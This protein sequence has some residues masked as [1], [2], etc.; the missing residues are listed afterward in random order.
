MSAVVLALSVAGAAWA[1]VAA[2][3]GSRKPDDI[4]D[5]KDVVDWILQHSG[6][7]LYPSQVGPAGWPGLDPALKTEAGYE[8]SKWGWP[9]MVPYPGAVDHTRLHRQRYL[10]VYP[11][12]NAR[13]LVKNFRA[14]EIPGI[15]PKSV[16]PYAEPIYHVPK[17]LYPE[18][19]RGRF[20]DALGLGKYNKPVQTLRFDKTSPAITLDLGTLK[21]SA[22]AVRVIAAIDT[23][24]VQQSTKRLVIHFEVNDGSNGEISAS[25]KRCAAND[26]FYSMAEFFFLAPV[27]RPYRIKLRVDASS[28]LS[29]YLHNIDLHD[30]LAELPN[31]GVKK[32]ASLYDEKERANK[33]QAA[34]GAKKDAR[35]KEQRLNADKQIM[36]AMLPANS[37]PRGEI[38]PWWTLTEAIFKLPPGQKDD[39]MGID[40]YGSDMIWNIPAGEQSKAVGMSWSLQGAV[41]Q[42]ER[43]KLQ[44]QT[45]YEKAKEI[46][47]K[48]K[49]IT[50]PR[51]LP[52]L[53]SSYEEAGD[54]AAARAAA[55][56]LARVALAELLNLDETRQTMAAVDCIPEISSANQGDISLRRRA[57]TKYGSDPAMAKAYDTIF[58][59]IR[60][61]AEL[62]ESLGRFIPWIKTAD[63]MTRFFEVALIQVPAR[64]TMLY[65]RQDGFHQGAWMTTYIV[66]QQDEKVV[67]PWMHWL[68]RFVWAYPCMPTGIDETLFTSWNH[69][70]TTLIASTF[71]TIGTTD[72]IKTILGN[73]QPFA[74]GLHAELVSRLKLPEVLSR[75]YWESRFSR[76]AMV[77]GGYRF[78]VGDVSGPSRGR[79][80]VSG[81][82]T[83]TEKVDAHNP[84]R[85]LANWFAV[86]ESNVAENDFRKRR[87]TGVRVGNGLGHAHA[88]PLDLQIWSL[89]VPLA[90]DWGAR[91]GYCDPD[92][93]SIEAHNTVLADSLLPISSM[94]CRWISAFAATEGAQ[95]LR[96]EVLVPGLYSRQLAL[97]DVPD[98][99]NSYLVD[100][101]RVR[102]GTN[103]PSY[104]FH[105]PPP[106]EF[107]TNIE[108]LNKGWPAGME[109]PQLDPDNNW[110]GAIDDA[111]TATWM[112]G[113]DDK[114]VEFK[115]SADLDLRKTITGRALQIKDGKLVLNVPGAERKAMGPDFNP[116]DPRK[117]IQMHLLGH[118][119]ATAYGRRGIGYKAEPFINDMVYVMPSEWKGQT[120]FPVVFEPYAGERLMRRVR[121]LSPKAT[122][123]NAESPVAIEVTL[124]NGRRDIIYSALPGGKAFKIP[125]VG[126]V[127]AEYAFLSWDDK[128]LRQAT[129]AGG[130][131]LSADGLKIACAK[132]AYAGTILECDPN[133]RTL[134]FSDPLPKEAVGDV[135]ATGYAL[136][137]TSATIAGVD[138][139]RATLLKDFT[140]IMSRISGFL[141]ED[142]MPYT[143]CKFY[144]PGGVAISNEK[145]DKWWFSGDA[146][147]LKPEEKP[148][149]EGGKAHPV[150]VPPKGRA[151]RLVNGPEPKST[152]R[153]GERLWAYEFGKGSSYRLPVK[154]NV[155]RG[156]NGTYT[157]EASIDAEITVAKQ[158]I[159]PKRK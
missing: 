132:G 17:Y 51:E 12:Y 144:I 80:V 52:G 65:N 14:T 146:Y 104:A 10:P 157:A 86:L 6:S 4:I 50:D 99:A 79:W 123:G 156:A 127:E 33:W 58:P 116:S 54:E 149:P 37:Q 70:G 93:T 74:K 22:Y 16:V 72:I 35:T 102:G 38:G 92:S 42:G 150:E 85:V 73:L 91:G 135:L 96:G 94:Q 130:T 143:Y 64:E 145:R 3:S 75:H 133:T 155:V 77:A 61:N 88:D 108:K 139:N 147:D 53:L 128:G 20:T 114:S 83:G 158:N 121:L 23:E 153:V 28:D 34:G 154:V 111:F 112:M 31:K 142:G 48:L 66:V 27:E 43:W 59:Y 69:D 18:P 87:A 101:F 19:D 129:L 44:R 95:Y 106:D 136:R 119:G 117:Y 122:L 21:P 113:R 62:A 60:G 110:H 120:V 140:L 57:Q 159:K 76:D 2:S 7:Q 55:V 11:L 24:K 36:D 81:Q 26:Q 89:G 105:G 141:E 138:G 5:V 30:R 25:R 56:L 71:Y 137:P 63:D 8:D 98:Q 109:A 126:Q 115:P 125:G 103:R 90:G 107:F 124:A 40:L 131:L 68:F 151:I 47:L 46:G 84:S 78:W 29:L 9:E 148:W 45:Y 1:E 100:V 49:Q 13:T 152:L 15:D 97:V 32:T 41:L 134:T 67:T 118:G 82:E 39:G